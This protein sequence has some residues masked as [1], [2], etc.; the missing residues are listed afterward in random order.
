MDR[1]LQEPH[2]ADGD[3]QVSEARITVMIEKRLMIEAAVTGRRIKE[4]AEIPRDVALYRRAPG[5]NE[6]IHDDDSVEV[7]D[8][9]HFF[10]RSS[11]P[12]FV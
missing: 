5:G 2:P 11:T 7:R 4:L 8:G 6:P 12:P 1:H 9:D 3:A 10:A